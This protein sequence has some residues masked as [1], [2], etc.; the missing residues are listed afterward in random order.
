[1]ARAVP[2]MNVFVVGLP[3][4]VIAAFVVIAATLPFVGG[5]LENDLQQAIQRTLSMLA[6][7]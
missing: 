3:V 6:T 1:V 4:K 2:Q 5:H 7:G